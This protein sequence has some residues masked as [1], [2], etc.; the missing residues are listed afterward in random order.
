ML[1]WL[2]ASQD[3]RQ[4]RRRDFNTSPCACENLVIN[5]DILLNLRIARFVEVRHA[6]KSEFRLHGC[7]IAQIRKAGELELRRAFNREN[8]Y[9]YEPP[10][11][12]NTQLSPRVLAGLR[13]FILCFHPPH[14]VA[15]ER[16]R[17]L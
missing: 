9:P 8:P 1:V 16:G 14:G 5:S 2:D 17:I 10:R 3:F 12:A 15:H 7:Y 6:I 13:F 4:R 11:A